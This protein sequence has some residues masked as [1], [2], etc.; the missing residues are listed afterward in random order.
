MRTSTTQRQV[1]VRLA[2]VKLCN[3]NAKSVGLL[4]TLARVSDGVEKL[5]SYISYVKALL[6]P[7][8]TFSSTTTVTL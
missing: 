5:H 4:A 7:A 1:N 6:P 2:D 8:P 3:L